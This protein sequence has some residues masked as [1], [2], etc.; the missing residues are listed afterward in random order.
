MVR[1]ATI[2]ICFISSSATSALSAD[3]QNE[4]TAAK[5]SRNP[6]QKTEH[7]IQICS[8]RDE[9]IILCNLLIFFWFTSWSSPSNTALSFYSALLHYAQHIHTIT[10]ESHSL[11]PHKCAV[12]ISNSE[13]IYRT[14]A[15]LYT[16]I[17]AT[18]RNIA[19]AL[20]NCGFCNVIR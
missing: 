13:R 1:N 15:R 3:R 12:A 17:S 2:I 14:I 18:T 7:K 8:R 11:L 16:I 4:C 19:F 5:A 20:M 6:D 9:L 10:T